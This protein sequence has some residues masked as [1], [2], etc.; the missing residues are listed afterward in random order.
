LSCSSCLLCNLLQAG[1]LWG[2]RSG[3][4]SQRETSASFCMFFLSPAGFI[5]GISLN[6]KCSAVEHR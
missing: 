4:R 2:T 1:L 3:M 5:L 6:R